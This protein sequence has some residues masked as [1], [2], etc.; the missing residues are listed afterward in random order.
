MALE[1][2]DSRSPGLEGSFWSVADQGVVSLGTFLTSIMLARSLSPGDYGAYSALLAGLLFLNGIHAALVTS[3]LSVEGAATDPATLR[4]YSTA[5]V[6]FT[7]VLAVPSGLL[8]AAPAGLV[9]SSLWIWAPVWLILWQVQETMRRSLMCGLGHKRAVWGDAVSYLGQAVLIWAG[10]RT[11]SLT[12]ERAFAIIALTS[13]AAAVLQAVQ[14]GLARVELAELRRL[15]RGFWKFGS[16]MLYGCFASVFG[17]Q[18][19]FWMLA[20]SKG[21]QETASL[22]AVANV[23]GVCHPLMFGL[24]NLLVPVVARAKAIGG[25]PLAWRSAREQGV[26]FGMVLLAFFGI[27]FLWPHTIL[28][29]LYGPASPYAG[30]V[31]PLRLFVVSYAFL[32][33]AQVLGLFLTGDG[34]ARAAFQV[35]LS[36][37]FSSLLLGLPLA[38]IWGT[39]CA[40]AGMLA[41]NATKCIAGAT[42]AFRLFRLGSVR[43]QA[44]DDVELQ[45]SA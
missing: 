37:A 10:W 2:K 44:H 1:N 13:G 18:A 27:L 23:L 4:R 28:A 6:L 7:I 38:Y 34:D 45:L 24:G 22:Q 21:P 42:Q 32:Y 36:G 40:C 8:L 17:S 5:G 33:V 12:L 19:F 39:A 26:R 3:P 41:V 14:A 11:G 35:Q 29:M 16:W 31:G 15:A 20:L 9:R 43:P 30:L 25:F